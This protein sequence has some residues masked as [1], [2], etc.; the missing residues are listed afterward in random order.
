MGAD[1]EGASRRGSRREYSY[2]AVLRGGLALVLQRE[3]DFSRA[4]L[5]SILDRIQS[6]GFFQDWVSNFLISQT[7]RW[8]ESKKISAKMEK[9]TG[10][11]FEWPPPNPIEAGCLIILDP[12]DD[13]IIFGLEHSLQ[14]FYKYSLNIITETLG[15]AKI[16]IAIDLAPIKK[17]IDNQTSNL[18]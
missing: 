4:S 10:K 18:T 6:H 5:K 1:I 9:E 14:E 2:P 7:K 15:D 17:A 11:G 12:K 16:M 8:E 3:F 13:P